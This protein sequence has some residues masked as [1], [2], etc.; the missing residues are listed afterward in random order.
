MVS[1]HL[2][3]TSTELFILYFK[4]NY[5]LI[6]YKKVLLRERKRHT[7][8]PVASVRSAVL[9]WLGGCVGGGGGYPILTCLRG[10][11]HPGVPPILTWPGGGTPS[12]PDLARGGIPLPRKDLGKNLGLGY[13]LPV[14]RVLWHVGKYYGMGYPPPFPVLDKVKT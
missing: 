6:Q 7:A 9:S 5:F 8:R 1:G 2:H 13:P 4:V 11:P 3:F 12:S 14:D 10:V